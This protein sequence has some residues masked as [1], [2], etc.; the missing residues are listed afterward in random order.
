MKKSEA[1]L[2]LL[3]ENLEKQKNKWY[4]TKPTD[5]DYQ[6]EFINYAECRAAYNAAAEIL[7]LIK[8]D[9]GEIIEKNLQE[10]EDKYYA[11]NLSFNLIMTNKPTESLMSAYVN[12]ERA[13]CR[14][15][16]AKA[17]AEKFSEAKYDYS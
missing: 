7:K 15:Q 9:A 4:E 13:R 5:I 1:Y 12:R 14:W 17:L 6:Y 11:E 16:G 8:D 3:N 10:L 2:K